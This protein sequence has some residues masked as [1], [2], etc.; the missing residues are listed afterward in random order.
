MEPQLN[1][2][3][4]GYDAELLCPSCGGNF[5]HHEVVEIF[6]RSE[7]E[8]KGIHLK[9]AEGQATIDNSLKGNPSARRHGLAIRFRCETCPSEPVFTLSQHKGST[10]VDFS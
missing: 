8:E 1:P 4:N 10:H 9:V 6:E 7:D 2:P 3:Q 5:L